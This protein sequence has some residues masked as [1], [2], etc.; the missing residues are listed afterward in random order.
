MW[1]N[2]SCN[3]WIIYWKYYLMFS[4]IWT[5]SKAIDIHTG[6]KDEMCF[7]TLEW[8][9]HL[10]HI[11]VWW[12]DASLKEWNC[13]TVTMHV[14]PVWEHCGYGW[15]S[16]MIEWFR[17]EVIMIQMYIWREIKKVISIS[18]VFGVPQIS[19]NY[20]KPLLYRFIVAFPSLPSK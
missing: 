9:L 18:F 12:P 15:M 19:D 14:L 2:S 17:V 20:T 16:M 13:A 3:H 6:A 11:W 10:W 1:G 5:N 8:K 4:E 7:V